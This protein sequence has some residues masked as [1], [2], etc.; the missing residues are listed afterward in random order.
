MLHL[1]AFDAEDLSVISAQMQDAVIR[2]GDI[3]YLIKQRQFVLV[4]N[5]FAWDA[6]PAKERRRSGLQ[7]TDV[8]G[9]K[10]MGPQAP[11]ADTILSLLAITFVP[12][13]DGLSGVMTLNFSGGHAIALSVDCIDVHLDDLGPAWTTELTPEHGA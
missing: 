5:R 11:V 9:A 2:F 1:T 7:I 10:R 12:A 13:S 4:A 8:T 3:R 6:T